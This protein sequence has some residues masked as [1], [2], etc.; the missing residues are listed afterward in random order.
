MP[1]SLA[2]RRIDLNGSHG[3]GSD[4]VRVGEFRAPAAGKLGWAGTRLVAGSWTR[5]EQY[6]AR[7]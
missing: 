1:P 3:T 2:L 7:L 5:V 4:Q 6:R